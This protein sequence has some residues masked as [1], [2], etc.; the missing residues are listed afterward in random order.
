MLVHIGNINP[1]RSQD[2]HKKVK[3]YKK[4]TVNVLMYER[5]VLPSWIASRSIYLKPLRYLTLDF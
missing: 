1:L 5:I 4:D 3:N 2:N